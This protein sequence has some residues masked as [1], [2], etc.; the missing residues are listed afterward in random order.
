MI[1]TF[2]TLGYFVTVE[3][4]SQNT[5]QTQHTNKNLCD[6]VYSTNNSNNNNNNYNN[7]VFLFK[8]SPIHFQIYTVMIQHIYFLFIYWKVF[9]V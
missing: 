2:Q 4:G 5:E 3:E 1:Y 9:F 8:Q 7:V 6:Q